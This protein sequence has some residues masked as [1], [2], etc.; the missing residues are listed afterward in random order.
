MSTERIATASSLLV[1]VSLVACSAVPVSGGASPAPSG[2]PPP[3]VTGDWNCLMGSIAIDPQVQRIPPVT[4][5]APAR[6]PP[7]LQPLRSGDTFGVHLFEAYSHADVGGVQVT[8]CNAYDP[9][10]ASP[11][12]HAQAD[13][14]GLA[15]LTVPGGLAGLDGYLRITGTLMPDNDVFFG[16]RVRAGDTNPVDVTVYTGP[17]LGITETLAGE[18]LDPQLGM[19]RVDAVDCAQAAAGGVGIAIEHG[20]VASSPVEYFTSD[21]EMLS[22]TAG[23]TDTSGVALV[24]GVSP[25]A[26]GFT[27]HVQGV[28]IGSTVGF[29]RAGAVSSVVLRPAGGVA[30][31]AP[32]PATSCC[33]TPGGVAC[34]ADLQGNDLVYFDVPGNGVVP[35]GCWAG[36]T[37]GL[38]CIEGAACTMRR[39]GQV[40][41]GTCGE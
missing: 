27:G 8:A 7:P 21:G 41:K 6:R 12:G 1:A 28:T 2:S 20:S 3:A 37:S 11:L 25:G 29:A 34:C 5:P 31:A 18:T 10:C 40:E 22:R 13:D 35:V 30:V 26:I 32:S 16:G 9:D 14:S 15:T 33:A 36:G 39:A 19:V 24:F 4:A 23:V 17:A 38:G